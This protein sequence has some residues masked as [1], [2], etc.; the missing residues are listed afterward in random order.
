MEATANPATV[1]SIND[2][3]PLVRELCG[4]EHWGRHWQF[5]GQTRLR[6]YWPLLPK[7]GRQDYFG[8]PRDMHMSGDNPMS[9][10]GLEKWEE[11]EHLGYLHPWDMYVFTQ[12]KRRAIAFGPLP[13]SDWECLALAQ[14]HGLATRLLDWTWNPL[15]AL[16]FA[17]AGEDAEDGGVYAW[18]FA[19]LLGERFA[20][21]HDV[22]TYEPRPFDRRIA[23]QQGVFTYH[24]RPT[25]AL[26]PAYSLSSA[27]NAFGTNLV[28]IIVPS[29]VKSMVLRDLHVFGISK[30]TLFPDWEGLSW[31]LNKMNQPQIFK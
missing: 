17:V 1:E 4:S 9:A 3:V 13:D 18:P 12:W 28:E 7:V 21:V 10:A 22:R 6:K 8:L 14:H 29:R 31:D 16:F 19:G 11:D 27:H 5:R 20:E 2:F 24:P 15:V 26:E 30:A 23:A 25:V